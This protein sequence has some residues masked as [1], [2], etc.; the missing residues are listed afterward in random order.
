MM[1][2]EQNHGGDYTEID[3][4]CDAWAKRGV[5]CENSAKVVRNTAEQAKRLAFDLGWRLLRGH[6]VCSCCLTR[7]VGN[8]R[9]PRKA[10]GAAK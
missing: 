5:R 9:F 3:I 2:K 7:G 6:Q 10:K 4:A 8:V 1:Y